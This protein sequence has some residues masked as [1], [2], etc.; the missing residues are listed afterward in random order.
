MIPDTP[1][2][3]LIPP[4]VI[5]GLTQYLKCST[6]HA[7]YC[8]LTSSKSQVDFLKPSYV[9]RTEKIKTALEVKTM[10]HNVFPKF[11]ADFDDSLRE[12]AFMPGYHFSL[13]MF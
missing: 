7:T 13:E 6:N 10:F 11:S 4:Q 2:W 9:T 3:L 8:A 1:P 12:I 5:L